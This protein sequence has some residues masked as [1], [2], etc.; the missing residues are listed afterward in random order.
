MDY[1][2]FETKVNEL[3]GRQ[4]EILDEKRAIQAETIEKM[5]ASGISSL[6]LPEKFVELDKEYW[7]ID[8]QL[9]N[10]TS[11]NKDIVYYQFRIFSLQDS[12]NLIDSELEKYEIL[13]KLNVIITSENDEW[14]PIKNLLANKKECKE[15]IKRCKEEIQKIKNNF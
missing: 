6:C 13:T 11:Y 12:I 9:W 14:N 10:A 3:K 2:F 8:E 5:Q 1:N 7:E 15:S 4:K